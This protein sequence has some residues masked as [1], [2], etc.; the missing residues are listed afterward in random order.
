MLIA[1]RDIMLKISWLLL[2]PVSIIH[3]KNR[4]ESPISLNILINKLKEVVSAVAPVVILV[5]ILNFRLHERGILVNGN[6][7]DG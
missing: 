1:A 2:F 4:R 7:S 5:I 3:L 6:R